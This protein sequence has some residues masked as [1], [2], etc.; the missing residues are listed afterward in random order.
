MRR[1]LSA[2]ALGC[3]LLTISSVMAGEER[4]AITARDLRQ[5]F[6][7]DKSTTEAAYLGKTILVKG[8]VGSTGMSIYLTPTVILSDSEDGPIQAIC[9]L[10]R[11]DVGKLSDFKPGQSVT[12]SGRVYRL[13]E[14][15]VVLKECQVAE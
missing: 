8:I 4:I 13:S 9:M 15:G 1:M 2:F 5:A 7:E 6:A 12:M 10:P 14:R 11:L 3:T